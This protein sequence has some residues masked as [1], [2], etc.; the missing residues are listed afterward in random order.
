[1]TALNHL[2][3]EQLRNITSASIYP[4]S[5]INFFCGENGSGKTS[6]L[7][8]IS[9][10]GL[11]RSFRNHQSRT[12]VN[13]TANELMV[14]ADLLLEGGVTPVGIKKSNSGGSVVRVA[15]ESIQS[16]IV[17]AKQLPLLI[18]NAHSF[19]LIEGP[20]LQRRQFLDWM[21]FHVKPNFSGWWK[22]LQK[23]LKQRNRLLR[24]DKI[25][26]SEI[27]P[28]DIEISRLAEAIDNARKS[29]FDRFL[30]HFTVLRDD[31]FKE[32]LV[33]DL[34]YVRGWDNEQALS[35]ILSAT[36]DRDVRYGYTHV[37]PQRAEIK[38]RVHKK[39]ANEVLSRGQEKALVCAL[40][41]TQAQLYQSVVGQDCVFLLDD[42]LAELDL[43]HSQKL[44]QWLTYLNG[45]VFITGVE[46]NSLLKAWEKEDA[47]IALFHVKQGCIERE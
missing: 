21:V 30:K 32:A 20:P 33:I 36:F 43:D 34:E 2:K 26:Y 19:Q 22:D 18:V 41:I 6:V 8:A 11:G 31:F 9:M 44:A 45:Q 38:I 27:R 10:L 7:E 5:K 13:R 16:A 14:Y 46:K 42:L 24:R 12:L 4:S 35:N 23:A 28:W 39:P 25:T 1:L 37:G 15:G 40:T 47:T 29:V 17:L 3:I